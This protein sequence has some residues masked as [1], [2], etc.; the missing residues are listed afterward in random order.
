[1]RT[2]PRDPPVRRSVELMPA[3]RRHPYTAIAWAVACVRDI[4]MDPELDRDIDD[5]DAR[6]LGRFL[7]SLY[8]LHVERGE[9][10]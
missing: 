10:T 7:H 5:G 3:E 4:T 2:D 6:W 9:S 8:R 1:M